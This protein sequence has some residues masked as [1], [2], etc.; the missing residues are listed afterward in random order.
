M[1][2]PVLFRKRFK[3]CDIARRLVLIPTPA[4]FRARFRHASE[5]DDWV[6]ALV[7]AQAT[8]MVVTSRDFP[9]FAARDCFK[10][11]NQWRHA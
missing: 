9:Y 6:G 7:N 11:V 3:P 5:V 2:T 4:G 1:V 10:H 8:S